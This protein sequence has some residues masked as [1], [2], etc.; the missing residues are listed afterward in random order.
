ML[1][2]LFK[3]TEPR[4]ILNSIVYWIF[5]FLGK[6]NF[7]NMY[8]I[9]VNFSPTL[10][11]RKAARTFSTDVVAFGLKNVSCPCRT[12]SLSAF[13]T[14]TT[15]GRYRTISNTTRQARTSGNRVRQ[16]QM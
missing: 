1:E 13:R 14:C 12:A 11:S 8:K 16:R 15:T 9:C 5:F 3:L 4:L 10:P 7:F 2:Y 6:A